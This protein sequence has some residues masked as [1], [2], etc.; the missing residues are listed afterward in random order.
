M[1]I[2]LLGHIIIIIIIIIMSGDSLSI[3]L[4]GGLSVFLE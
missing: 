2:H 1:L 4:D 3:N